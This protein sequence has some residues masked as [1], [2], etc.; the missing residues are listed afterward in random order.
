MEG[1]ARGIEDRMGAR[2]PRALR[3]TLRSRAFILQLGRSESRRQ[4]SE[5]KLAG[6]GNSTDVAGNGRNRGDLI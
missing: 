2:V 6:H 5:V 3:V 4:S 1:Q